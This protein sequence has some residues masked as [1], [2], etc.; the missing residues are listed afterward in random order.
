MDSATVQHFVIELHALLHVHAACKLYIAKALDHARGGI[1]Y[2][3]GAGH[4]AFLVRKEASQL[5]VVRLKVQ[6]ADKDFIRR[7]FRQRVAV[8]SGSFGK[9]RGEGRGQKN[10]RGR[11]IRDVRGVWR[12]EIV[13][14]EGL[15]DDKGWDEEPKRENKKEREKEEDA[16]DKRNK[17]ESA[18]KPEAS[19]WRRQMGHRAWP[20]EM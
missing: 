12:E 16:E 20:S 1:A 8:A 7:V 2:D 10:N 4:I 19:A 3:I 5:L 15:R 13:V 11:K 18:V 9:E 17:K 14:M 6:V